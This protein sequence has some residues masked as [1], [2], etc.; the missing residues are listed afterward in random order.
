M[1]L[2]MPSLEI[3]KLSSCSTQLSIKLIMLIN[4][5]IPSILGSKTCINLTNTTSESFKARNIGFFSSLI[6]MG[7]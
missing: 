5:K 1:C 3:I 6:L 7:S 2:F 4:A